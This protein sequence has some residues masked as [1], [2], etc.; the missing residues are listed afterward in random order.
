MRIMSRYSRVTRRWGQDSLLFS[1]GRPRAQELG[2]HLTLSLRAGSG[3]GRELRR[4]MGVTRNHAQLC[5]RATAAR[6][7]ANDLKNSTL[8]QLVGREYREQGLG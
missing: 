7:L 2:Y 3:D 1:S 5:C 8:D 6:E 4:D